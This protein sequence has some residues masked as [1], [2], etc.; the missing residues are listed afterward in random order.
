MWPRLRAALRTQMQSFCRPWTCP[1]EFESRLK[2][3][4]LDAFRLQF[5]GFCGIPLYYVSEWVAISLF[6]QRLQCET[7]VFEDGKA[8]VLALL[9]QLE[10]S[11]FFD[12]FIPYNT[13]SQFLPLWGEAFSAHV[14]HVFRAPLPRPISS[15]S[16]SFLRGP[17][18]LFWPRLSICSS[19][20][21][22]LRFGR[23][24]STIFGHNLPECSGASDSGYIYIYIYR[25][26]ERDIHT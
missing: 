18:D 9:A 15:S 11:R 21:S 1:F 25:E 20:V 24:W 8:L 2:I 17:E 19:L 23:P 6:L 3:N 14:K 7:N 26:R 13:N 5:W 4:S 12:L 22:R 16:G 10:N